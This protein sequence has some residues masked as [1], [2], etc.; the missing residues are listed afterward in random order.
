MRTMEATVQLEKWGDSL[1]IRLPATLVKALDL[2]EGDEIE[3]C[4]ARRHELEVFRKP[5]RQELLETLRAFRGKLP[6]DYKFDRDDA[7]AR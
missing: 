6:A 7:N 3:I 1:A 2:K 5:G 4:I